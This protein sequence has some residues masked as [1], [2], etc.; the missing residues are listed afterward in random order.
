LIL[1]SVKAVF[2][3]IGPDKDIPAP[4]VNT[5]P[6]IMAWMVDEYIKK[7]KINLPAGKA[8]SQKSKVRLLGTFTGKP[9]ELWGLKGRREATGYGGAVILKALSKKLNLNPQKTTIAIQ[10]FGNVGYYF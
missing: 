9:E 3:W 5:N 6:Q 10:G 8:G 7:S 2:S 4:D 1:L